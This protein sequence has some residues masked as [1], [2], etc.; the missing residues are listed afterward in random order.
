MLGQIVRDLQ[1]LESPIQEP[2]R[3]RKSVSDMSLM[4]VFDAL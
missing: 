4:L 1:L 2:R 3:E